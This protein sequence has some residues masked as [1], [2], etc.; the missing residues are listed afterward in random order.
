MSFALRTAP[1]GFA[2]IELLLAL[3]L[4][5][6]LSAAVVAL[7]AVA[8]SF[9]QLIEIRGHL[10]S[11]AVVAATAMQRELL[12]AGYGRCG[13]LNS[14]L[15]R[16]IEVP[17][18]YGWA[19][20]RAGV[21][22]WRD[23]AG[24]EG[25]TIRY[26]DSVGESEILLHSTATRSL[27]LASAGGFGVGDPV[28]LTAAD[29]SS[30]MLL[31]LRRDRGTRLHYAAVGKISGRDCPDC[32]P[33]SLQY[34]AG[35]TI[36]RWRAVQYHTAVSAAG[37]PVLM[38]RELRTGRG[39]LRTLS[40]PFVAD[41]EQLGLRLGVDTDATADGRVDRYLSA[42]R[43]TAGDWERVRL[44]RLRLSLRSP[45]LLRLPGFGL[46]LDGESGGDGY[47]RNRLE[48]AVAMRNRWD[49]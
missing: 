40:R 33:A 21:Q 35:S 31:Q 20:G 12:L 47:L 1:A 14:P 38:R 28:L 34:P 2:L 10:A 9:A 8:A 16:A 30:S 39:G 5:A 19:F 44:V 49:N 6:V 4:G 24:G 36:S 22:A 46:R 48:F 42:D 27:L 29:C 3:V 45:Q 11:Q 37:R 26:A 41:V 25:I 15:L 17:P 43:M 13:H 7:L 18:K 32:V 23:P